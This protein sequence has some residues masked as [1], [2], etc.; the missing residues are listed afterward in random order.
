MD[1]VS[2]IASVGQLADLTAK[3]FVDLFEYYR[4]VKQAPKR[5]AELRD[6]LQSVSLL[7][8]Q[9]KENFAENP[10]NLFSANAAKSIER[11]TE[12]FEK[13]LQTLRDRI[14]CNRT[15][16]AQRLIWP[17]SSSENAEYLSRIERY[18]A[19]FTLALSIKQTFL[20]FLPL[21]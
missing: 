6:E 9:V 2:V 11:S 12:E 3:I 20:P 17:F 16:G 10:K 4:V 21:N 5:S 14:G 18:K 15:K 8:D 1:A 13:L 7:L 19:I